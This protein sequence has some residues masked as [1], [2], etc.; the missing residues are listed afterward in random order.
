MSEVQIFQLL[1]LVFFSAGLGLLINPDFYRRALHNIVDYPLLA[2]LSGLASLVVGYLLV[3]FNNV[4]AWDRLFWITLV[5]W[6]ALIKGVVILLLP[7]WVDKWVKEV[8]E[9]YLSAKAIAA[10]V[11]GLIFLSFGFFI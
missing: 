5:G 3:A 9:K 1:G 11:L 10:A 4:W 7:A 8:G 6:C 2:Y